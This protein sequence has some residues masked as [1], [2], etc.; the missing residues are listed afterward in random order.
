MRK[1]AQIFAILATYLLTLFLLP[2]N[3]F[4]QFLEQTNVEVTG[5]CHKNSCEIG[6]QRVQS[7]IDGKV[8]EVSA[9]K[10]LLNNLRLSNT[11]EIELSGI[12]RWTTP[13]WCDARWQPSCSS[14]TSIEKLSS[15]TSRIN[16]YFHRILDSR[17]TSPSPFLYRTLA[18]LSSLAVVG[19][20]IFS[21]YIKLR[22]KK[23]E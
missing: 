22:K 5:L 8:I 12:Y 20:G 16:F 23:N 10:E 21:I 7:F 3:A 4:S 11:S 18:I 14:R 9:P 2:S 13:Q 15:N 19:T 1:V 6:Y 17:N